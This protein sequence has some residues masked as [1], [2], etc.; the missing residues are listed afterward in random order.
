MLIKGAQISFTKILS[1]QSGKISQTITTL[2]VMIVFDPTSELLPWQKHDY[3]NNKI[4]FDLKL[5]PPQLRN[6]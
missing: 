1:K 2:R 5:I 3:Q 6:R 4:R